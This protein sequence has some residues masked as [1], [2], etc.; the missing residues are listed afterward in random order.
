MGFSD[1]ATVGFAIRNIDKVNSGDL[2][3]IPVAAGQTYNALKAGAE[4]NSLFAKGSQGAVMAASD[5]S[6][7]KTVSNGVNKLANGVKTVANEEPVL[8][9]ITK[10]VKFASENV[11]TLICASSALKVLTSEKEERKNVLISEAG[12]IAGMFLGEGWMKKNLNKY[13]DKL[14]I[15]KK[16]VPLIRGALFIAGSIGAST[17]GQKAG[18]KVAQYWDKPL[19]K[20]DANVNNTNEKQPVHVDYKA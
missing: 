11:N 8:K 6:V 1:V 10:G 4:L 19:K 20:E 2:G 14:P 15:D 16:F 5:S 13:L 7:L 18:K 17:L 12:C 3:R 9:A